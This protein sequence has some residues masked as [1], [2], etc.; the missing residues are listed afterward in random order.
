MFCDKCG[1][2]I[3]D[4][5]KFCEYCGGD[6]A[7]VATCQQCGNE[8]KMESKFCN[9]CGKTVA[10]MPQPQNNYQQPYQQPPSV[11]IMTPPPFGG[12]VTETNKLGTAGLIFA[13]V[14]L[15][16]SCSTT[17]GWL[18]RIT[19]VILSI[20]GLSKKP[21]GTAVAGLTISLVNSAIILF[22]YASIASFLDGILDIFSW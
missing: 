13:L 21:N 16:L 11:V 15:F 18:C 2:Q 3:E 14:A 4:S 20:A 17:L 7:N 5:S 19:A 9:N 22:L 8:L 10:Y 12:V 1:K 6:V